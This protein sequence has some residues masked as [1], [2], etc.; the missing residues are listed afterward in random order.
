MSDQA[1]NSNTQAALAAGR[2]AI[3]QAPPGYGFKGK[4]N[5]YVCEACRGKTVT[6]DLEAGVT[7]FLI[8]CRAKAGCKG[9]AQSLMYRCDQGLQETHQWVLPKPTDILSEGELDHVAN[10]GLLLRESP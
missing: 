8:Q 10:G 5:V 3:R 6:R 2:A 7:P 4:V 1:A 9:H